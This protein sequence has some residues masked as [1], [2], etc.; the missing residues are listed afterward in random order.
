MSESHV[1]EPSDTESIPH[2]RH[3]ERTALTIYGAMT[4][5]GVLEASTTKAV[6]DSTIAVIILIIATSLAIVIAHAWSTVVAHRLVDGEELSSPR[7]GNELWFAGSFLIP[8]ILAVATVLIAGLFTDHSWS[9]FIAQGV[10]L[11]FLFVAGVMGSRRGGASWARALTW[12]LIDVGVGL[13]IVLIKE[14]LYVFAH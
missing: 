10:L 13:A 1:A 11:V 5:L 14:I 6:V 2:A 3:V 9:I 12:G 4:L 7:V 8:A